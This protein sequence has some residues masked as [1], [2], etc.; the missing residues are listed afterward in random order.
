MHRIGRT[1]RNNSFSSAYIIYKNGIEPNIKRLANKKIDFKYLL[2]NKDNEL[3][4]KPLKFKVVKK[5]YFDTKTNNEIKK[6]ISTNSHRVRPGYKKKIKMKI[7]K[8]RQKKKHEF[9]EKKIKQQLLLRNI[10]RTKE[11]KFN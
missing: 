3:I 9:I 1:G 7:D 2:A 11:K 4:D 6:I 8:I 10:K 5:I